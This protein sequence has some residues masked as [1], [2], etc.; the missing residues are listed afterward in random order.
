MREQFERPLEWSSFEC[1]RVVYADQ[2]D[3]DEQAAPN[4]DREEP[5]ISAL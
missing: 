1:S 2:N 3:D 5:I 4:V